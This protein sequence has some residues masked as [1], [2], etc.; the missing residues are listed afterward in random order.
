MAD[1]TITAANVAVVT[2]SSPTVSRSYNAGEAVTAGQLVYLNTADS[3]WYKAQADGT[4]LEA[5]SA[6]LGVAL[7]TSAN[8]QPLAVQTAGQITIGGTVVAGTEYVASDTA[9]GICPHADLTATG[10]RYS[11]VGYATTTGIIKLDLL[12]SGVQLA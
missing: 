12:A 6:G 11:R 1:I 2:T 10:R 7:H 3:E 4:A 5:G 9:G 8:G